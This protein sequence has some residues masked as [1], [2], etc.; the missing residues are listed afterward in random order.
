[1]PASRPAVHTPP[2]E[3]AATSSSCMTAQDAR[4]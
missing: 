4:A 2:A 1:M 3:Q